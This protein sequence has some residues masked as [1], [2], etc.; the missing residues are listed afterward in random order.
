MHIKRNYTLNKKFTC[1][2]RMSGRTNQENAYLLNGI[3][4]ECYSLWLIQ[5]IS[6]F[7]QDALRQSSTLTI[8]PERISQPTQELSLLS[9]RHPMKKIFF[10]RNALPGQEVKEKREMGELMRCY[11]FF[12]FIIYNEFPF[13]LLLVICILIM[14]CT[15][16]KK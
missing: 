9:H 7:S 10:L 16:E 3:R 6:W 1:N 5:K 14:Q 8:F 12:I 13:F 2:V 15:W 4:V 11:L